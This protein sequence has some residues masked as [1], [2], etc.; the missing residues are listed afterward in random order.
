MQ[1]NS[2]HC[3]LSILRNRNNDQRLHGQRWNELNCPDLRC[4][5]AHSCAS[6][7]NR[8]VLVHLPWLPHLQERKLNLSLIPDSKKMTGKTS[9]M[10]GSRLTLNLQPHNSLLCKQFVSVKLKNIN[11]AILCLFL[12]LHASSYHI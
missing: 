5:P 4:P 9:S 12:S 2:V 1:L 8:V 10:H 6:L 7:L 11:F 3:Q